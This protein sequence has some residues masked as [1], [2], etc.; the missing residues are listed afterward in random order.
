MW[1]GVEDSQATKHDLSWLIQGM[2][3][4]T[5]I[6][7]IDGSY[8]RK[9]ASVISGVGWIIFCQMT[10]K[11]L[12]GS[13]WEK[14]PLASLYRAELLGLCLLHLFALALSK[15]YKV[16]GWKATLGCD[17]LRA[18][19]L[20]S[21]ERRRIKPSA[22]CSDI[23]R[24]FRSTK[25]NFT[26]CFKY[27]H[28]AG[29]M[30]KYLLWHQ[31]SLIQQL[32]C[33]CDT[34]A[35]AAVHSDL[36]TGYTSTP[37]QILPRQDIS[38]VIWGNKITSNVSQPVQFHAS[39]ELARK[40]LTDTKKWPQEQFEEVDWEHLDLA[41]TSKSNMYK[42]WRSKQHT[43]FCGTRVQVGR[44]S[45]HECPDK[46]CPTCRHR[47]TAEHIFTCPN[48]DRT[49]LLVEMTEDHS[50]WLN[51][52]HLTDPKLAYWIP[53]YIMMRGNKPFASLGAM[54]PR[55]KALAINQDKIGW[56]NFMEGCIST[57]FYFIQHY[58]LVLS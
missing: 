7:V 12:V 56:R 10:G 14:S 26:K 28:V 49:R 57:H 36:T 29:H 44:Y 43:G 32:N 51:Q 22:A 30:D 46:K 50:M 25:K 24:S 9:R 6:W 2:E 37:T 54:S 17:N 3:T 21:K 16:S 4:N 23:H 13:F 34:T 42:M 35:K 41:M 11:R 38:I 33:V 52:E 5:L 47:E 45:D 20:S 31:L 27:Q 39:K 55:M 19:I 15:F 48:E 40:L 58:H 18:L 53:K 8:D 1:E